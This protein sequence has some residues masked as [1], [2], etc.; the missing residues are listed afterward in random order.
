MMR[1]YQLRKMISGGWINIADVPTV[2]LKD[3][4]T[5]SH[6]PASGSLTAAHNECSVEDIFARIEIEL[7]A[8]S[9]GLSTQP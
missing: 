5:R 7:M 6:D 9:L 2:H 4:L 8:R 1:D 3:M